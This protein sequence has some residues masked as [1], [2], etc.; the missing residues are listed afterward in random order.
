MAGEGGDQPLSV[1]DPIAPWGVSS[2]C[3][4]S[5]AHQANVRTRRGRLFAP[6]FFPSPHHQGDE[7][8]S[9]VD[10]PVTRK[11]SGECFKSRRPQAEL[12]G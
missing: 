9:E 12:A 5:V 3:A 8:V 10:E 2:L 11:R 4:M 1:A 7:M 6:S